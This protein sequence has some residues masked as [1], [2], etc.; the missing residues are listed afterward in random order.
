MGKGT[1]FELEWFGWLSFDVSSWCDWPTKLFVEV[2]FC[3][4]VDWD[5]G[6]WFDDERGEFGFRRMVTDD[7]LL[8][9]GSDVERCKLLVIDVDKSS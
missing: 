6:C 5:D 3:K 7:E 8:N 1:W 2:E 9:I 4:R